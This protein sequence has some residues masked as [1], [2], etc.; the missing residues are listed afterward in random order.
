MTRIHRPARTAAALVLAL[1]CAAA[2]AMAETVQATGT[3]RAE[4]HVSKPLTQR[5]I[6][7]AVNQARSLAVP[8]AYINTSVQAAR[9]ASA[10][11]LLLGPVLSVGEPVASPFVYYGSYSR[12]GGDQYCGNVTTVK[13]RVVNG[14]RKVVSRHKRFRCFKPEYVTVQLSLTFAAAPDPSPVPVP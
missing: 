12:F 8:R 9:Y 2:P 13:R 5:K 7:H 11:H 6:A 4:V 1:G 10:A 3:G 14:K